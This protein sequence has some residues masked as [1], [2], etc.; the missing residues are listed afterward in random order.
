M[1]TQTPAPVS[2]AGSKYLLR[3]P[4]RLH[5][6]LRELAKTE[7]ISLNTLIAI[8]LAGAV[9]YEFTGEAAEARP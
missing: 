6:R 3:L 9:G 7:G 1:P 4:P 5:Q 2:A 8:L